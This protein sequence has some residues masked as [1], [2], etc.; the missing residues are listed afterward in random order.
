MTAVVPRINPKL[1]IPALAEEFQQRGK[2]RISNVL[3]E[4][5]A[6]EV[7]ACL[8]KD[9]P[10]RLMYYN[11]LGKG[12]E[13]VGRIYPRQWEVMSERQKQDLVD[14]IHQDAKDKF[15][16]FYNAYD[17]L[18]ARRK[19]HDPNLYLQK[20]LDFMGSDELF[21]FVQQI[22]GDRVFNRVDCHA[23]RYLP[24]HFL[25]E[26]VDSSPFEKRHMAYVFN[27]NRNWDADYGGLTHFLD[28]QHRVIETFI[29]D[30]NSLTLFRVPVPHSVSVVSAFA[31]NPRY[32][33]TGWFTRY[34]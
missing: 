31:P 18:V 14:R 13:V 12:P 22:S 33:I 27:F 21:G 29:P 20:F 3:N 4:E 1:D 2:I 10:W 32:S 9:V 24:G 16:Y 19:G 8:Q 7:L 28:D 5:F 6:N 30:F 11:H 34:N 26:H 25:K 17:V 15:Q 23:C